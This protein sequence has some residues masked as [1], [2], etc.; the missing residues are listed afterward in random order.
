MNK[1][2]LFLIFLILW[3]SQCFSWMSFPIG[4]T[5]YGWISH[6]IDAFLLLAYFAKRKSV[7]YTFSKPIMC[8]MLIPF[9]SIISA[10]WMN[11]QTF[12]K[13]FIALT[14]QFT[15][16]LYFLFHLYHYT[17]KDILRVVMIIGVVFCCIKIV[18]Q[19][20][21]PTMW[22]CAASRINEIT[23]LVEQRNGF[24]RIFMSCAGCAT[25]MLYYKFN[26]YVQTKHKVALI[27]V[28]LGC[29]NV[30]LDLGRMGYAST[31][32][33]L[34]IVYIP[35][36]VNLKNLIRIGIVGLLAYL[37]INNIGLILGADMVEQTNKDMGEDYVRWL[38]YDYYWSESIG[39][40]IYLLFGHGPLVGTAAGLR[41][42]DIEMNS[43]LWRSDIGIVGNI[44]DYGILYAISIVYFFIFI[45]KRT[46]NIRW[47]FG[48]AIPTFIFS[49]MLPVFIGPESYIMY[50]M[51]LY[52]CDIEITECKKLKY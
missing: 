38:S 44:Y 15:F 10:V 34:A 18:Q 35:D 5:M 21:Y 27:F 19:I 1:K 40:P 23:G 14:G 29:I 2:Q 46:K 22:F 47:M 30:F 50:S 11:G 26:E 6:I 52:L 36:F 13:G 48:Y 33:G 12:M 9:L 51:M 28:L 43:G 37:V 45:F 7:S 17:K 42:Q 31:L 20:T 32:I 49:F 39:S 8:V 3:Y 4:S 16:I 25:I 41:L 24:W